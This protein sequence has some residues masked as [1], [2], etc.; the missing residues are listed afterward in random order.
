MPSPPSRRRSP[1]QLLAAAE[2][3]RRSKGIL[4]PRRDIEIFVLRRSTDER[5]FLW[6]IRRFGGVVL[7]TSDGDYPTS[8]A[9]RDA[10]MEARAAFQRGSPVRPASPVEP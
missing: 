2:A 4:R 8:E 6:Q 1:A 3:G 9:A 7:L 5:S 10:G